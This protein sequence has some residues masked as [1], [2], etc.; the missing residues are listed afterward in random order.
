MAQVLSGLEPP[1]L[2]ALVGRLIPLCH[3][4][5]PDDTSPPSPPPAAAP[6]S[7]RV[8]QSALHALDTLA[9]ARAAATPLTF[10]RA[11]PALVSALSAPASGALVPALS[12]T[13]ALIT[14]MGPRLVPHLPALGDAL[15]RAAAQA[16]IPRTAR[17]RAPHAHHHRA[18]HHHRRHHHHHHHHHHPS[19]ALSVSS[20]PPAASLAALAAW[21]DGPIL[22]LLRKLPLFTA[23]LVP[24]I[25]RIAIS[26]AEITVDSPATA[27]TIAPRAATLRDA[28]AKALPSR[29]LLPPLAATLDSAAQARSR[30]DLGQISG[31]S[32]A[33]LGPISA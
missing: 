25:L 16:P 33:D 15:I 11:I 29:L 26:M 20:P 19:Q 2:D 9:R 31:R 18:A 5:P 7:S 22:S 1:I 30:A 13:S 32:R 6:P 24:R 3:P 14:G 21:A 8:Q 28:L 10:E 17:A 27:P 12:A 23:P 4:R